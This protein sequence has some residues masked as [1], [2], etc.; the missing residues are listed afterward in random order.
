MYCKF[1]LKSYQELGRTEYVQTSV[2]SKT[3]VTSRPCQSCTSSTQNSFHSILVRASCSK[4]VCLTL[5][6]LKIQSKF[7]N[8]LNK[9]AEIHKLKHSFEQLALD[10]K[11]TF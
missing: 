4:P 11:T 9:C 8:N 5:G 10:L 7:S 6:Q 3:I 1:L 2:S